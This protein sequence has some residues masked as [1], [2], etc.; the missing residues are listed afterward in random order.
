MV[1]IL[2][3]VCLCIHV[4]GMHV[5][6]HIMCRNQSFLPHVGMEKQTHVSLS[7]DMHLICK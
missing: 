2:L 5:F 4:L 1:H 6:M 3:N 7:L